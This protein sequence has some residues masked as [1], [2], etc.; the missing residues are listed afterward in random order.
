M[1]FSVS[2]GK[3]QIE[4]SVATS[5]APVLVSFDGKRATG[6]LAMATS[7]APVSFDGMQAR[8]EEKTRHHGA[9]KCSWMPTSLPLPTARAESSMLTGAAYQQ[10]CLL[11]SIS[12][13]C[14]LFVTFESAHVY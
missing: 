6:P 12:S 1:R 9:K 7:D 10:T 13:K 3:Y 2:W 14:D 5:D 8:L 11:L 4:C